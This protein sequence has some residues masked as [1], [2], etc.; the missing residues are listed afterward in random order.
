MGYKEK[1]RYWVNV[2][3]A[4]VSEAPYFNWGP[5]QSKMYFQFE[6]PLEWRKYRLENYNYLVGACKIYFY[7]KGTTNIEQ[8]GKHSTFN[9]LHLAWMLKVKCLPTIQTDPQL[10]RTELMILKYQ[11]GLD[12][13]LLTLLLL[14]TSVLI[15]M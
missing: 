15:S 10:H 8:E 9:N 12:P 14:Q 5:T 7:F 13:C 4:T 6:I 2:F 3:F 1:T 11:N